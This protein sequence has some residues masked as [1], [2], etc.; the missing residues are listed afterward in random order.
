MNPHEIN[1]HM[2][3]LTNANLKAIMADLPRNS[4]GL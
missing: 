3:I 4:D 1:L 2:L